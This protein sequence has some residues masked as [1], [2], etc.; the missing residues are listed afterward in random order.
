LS[1][2]LSVFCQFPF[3][4]VIVYLF[5]VF[6]L[7]WY[8]LSFVSFPLAMKLSVFCLSWP[9]GNWQKTDNN[10]AKGKLTKTDNIM[11][12]R[13]L[14]KDIQYHGMILSVF[15]QFPFGHVIVYLLSVFLLPCYRLSLSVSL[16]PWHCQAEKRQTISW[17]KGNW[18]KIDNN[19]AKGKLTKDRQYHGQREADKRQKISWPKGSWKKTDTI[20][21]KGKLTKDRQ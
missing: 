15:C 1:M 4:H 5:S 11:D 19:M 18:H 3:G 9:K 8:R 10:I 7:P 17:T 12:K 20:M 14:K 21:A 2:I 13:K 16:W 6:L